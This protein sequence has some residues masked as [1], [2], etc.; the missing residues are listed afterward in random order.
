[1]TTSH[2]YLDKKLDEFGKNHNK[3]ITDAVCRQSEF[4]AQK[5]DKQR[6]QEC[7]GA[8]QESV[9]AGPTQP[10]PSLRAISQS[11]M[12]CGRKIIFDNLDYY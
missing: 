8:S 3:S 9:V 2:S 11:S 7:A 1:M 5:R 6:I 4:M 10:Q 12:D